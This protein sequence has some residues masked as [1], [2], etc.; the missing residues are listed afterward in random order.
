MSKINPTFIL[1]HSEVD[2]SKEFLLKKILTLYQIT[3][4]CRKSPQSINN[5]NACYCLENRH[6]GNFDSYL[7]SKN[8]SFCS[9]QSI[10]WRRTSLTSKTASVSDFP[11]TI[12][13][14]Y[15]IANGPQLLASVRL[16]TDREKGVTFP[17][18]PT[19]FLY[20]V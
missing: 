9:R 14:T 13:A 2:C 19:K 17:N 3:S 8:S 7:H 11:S 15:G 6:G 20:N 5:E 4:L 12:F 16:Y 18:S 1:G 10:K